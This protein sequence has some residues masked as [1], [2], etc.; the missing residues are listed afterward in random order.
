MNS[1]SKAPTDLELA[2]AAFPVFTFALLV[3]LRRGAELAGSAPNLGLLLVLSATITG[4]L[5]LAA[6]QAHRRATTAIIVCFAGLAAAAALAFHQ[7]PDSGFDA[8]TYHLPSVLRLLNGWK[9]IIEPTDLPLL[10]YYPSGNWTILAGFDAIFG[11]ES[12]R[13]IGPVLMVAAGGAVW[14]ILRRT[15]MA[16]VP[17]AIVTVL[18]V[19]N[20]VAVSQIFT[21]YADGVLYELALI[22]ICSLLMMVEDR[23][24]ATTMLACAA[25]ILVFNTKLAGLFF[26][27]LALATWGALLLFRFRS[28]SAFMRERR[29]QLAMLIVA[30]LLAAG[31]V[32]WRP[33]VINLLEHHRLV[34][35]PADQLGYKPGSGNQLPTNLSTA[36][37]IPKLAALFFARTDIDGGPVTFK[38]PGTFGSD[39]LRMSNDIRN[40]GFGPFFGAAT[41]VALAALLWATVRRRCSRS[42]NRQLIEAMLGL[43][44]YGLMTTILFPEPWWARFV[45]LAWVIPIAAVSLAG[46]M[47]PQDMFIQSC[48]IICMA[49]STLNV[50]IAAI[51]AVRDGVRNAAD[52]KQQL[53]RMVRDQR[54]VYLSRGPIVNARLGD[55]HAAEDVWQRRIWDRGKTAVVILPRADCRKIEL[56][57]PDVARCASPDRPP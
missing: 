8:Q 5:M 47:R 4:A 17:R 29:S 40:G 49:L 2:A 1:S 14:T 42:S 13:A 19:A 26:A 18:L 7:I 11:F 38:V 51:S 36:G 35:P 24:P 54:P 20:P 32:G 45:P 16:A 37:R 10:N 22:L 56:L 23:R 43:T 34:Y 52:I 6:G 3:I 33:Y 27:S 12:G 46:T 41:V 9:P 48:T 21:A 53:E 31:F 25:V 44:V 39:E 50:A 30:G 57:R 15:G 55:R 28:A